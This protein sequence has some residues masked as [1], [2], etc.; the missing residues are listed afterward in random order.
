MEQIRFKEYLTVGDGD[1]IGRDVSGDIARL[2]LDDGQCSHA[3]A[4]CLVAEACCTLKKSGVQVEYIA[5]VC[6]SSGR[7]L[8]QQRKLTVSGGLL[9]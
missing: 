3:A 8:E 7:S 9:G 4:A 6:F 5:G 1:D 2:R